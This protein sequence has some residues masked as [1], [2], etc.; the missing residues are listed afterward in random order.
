VAIATGPNRSSMLSDVLRGVPT[1]I[2]V[3]N[4]VIVREGAA[5]G[6]PTPVNQML[7]WLIKAVEASYEYH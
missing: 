6:I 5:L 2:D 7:V 1:E 4:N 3:I